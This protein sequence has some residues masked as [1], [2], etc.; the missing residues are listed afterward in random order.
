MVGLKSIIEQHARFLGLY[1]LHLL[2]LGIAF[3]IASFVKDYIFTT[4]GEKKDKL[5]VSDEAIAQDCCSPDD[6][7]LNENRPNLSDSEHE[8]NQIPYNH[9]NKLT[10]SDMIK[11]AQDFYDFMNQRRS[12][13]FISKER[14]PSLDLIKTII[15]TAGTAPSGAHMQPWTF[16]VVSNKTVK[17]EIRKIIEEEEEVNYLK[18]MGAKWVNDLKPLNTNW[19]KPYLE[20]A[21]YL[22]LIFKQ[23]YGITSEGRQPHYYNE[24]STCIATGILLTA[25]HNAGLVTV[26]TTPLNCGPRLSTLLQRP[27]N[28]KLLV[29]LPVGFA[30]ADAT[31]PN[32]ERKSIDEIMVQF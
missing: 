18:R 11:R 31:V 21:P 13:R 3:F 15:H 23:V 6:L 16:V 8:N 12:V 27:V 26:T 2:A 20:D 9:T 24:I 10:E 28:E 1:W 30:A 25:I 4:T 29:L 32:L 14:V 5:N 17:S 7:L 19:C 22:I